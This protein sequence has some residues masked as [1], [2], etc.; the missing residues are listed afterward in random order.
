MEKQLSL[1]TSR[2]NSNIHD[3]EDALLKHLPFF[4]E[5]LMR[6]ISKFQI[7]TDLEKHVNIQ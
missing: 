2:L 6:T 1:V 3:K 7:M 5:I 4:N